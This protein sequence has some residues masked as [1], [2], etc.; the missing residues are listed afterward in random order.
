[1]IEKIEKIQYLISVFNMGRGLKSEFITVNIFGR[2][3]E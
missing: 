3:K 2:K 1:M